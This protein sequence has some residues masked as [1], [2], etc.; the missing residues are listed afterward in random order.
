MEVPSLGKHRY[1]CTLV[2]DK[3]G[4]LWYHPCLVK[5]DFTPWFIKMD[6][7]FLNHYQSHVKIL[8]S[9]HSGEYVNTALEEYCTRNGIAMELTVPHTPEQNGVAERANRKILDKGCT[10]MKDA[11]APDFLWADAFA[12]VIYAINRT[13]GGCSSSMTPFEAFF[14]EKPDI[15]HMWVWYSDVFIHQP[16]SLGAGKLGEWGHQVKFLGYPDNSAGYR[17]YDPL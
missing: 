1:F 8:G 14:G 7:L 15:S 4:F 17:T 11:N 6:Y 5:L 10:I 16:K 3:T 2:D 12:M 13:A 9:D